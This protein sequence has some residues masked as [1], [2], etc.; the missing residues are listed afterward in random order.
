MQFMNDLL[1]DVEFFFRN[2]SSLALADR[3]KLF[4]KSCLSKEQYHNLRFQDI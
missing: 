3:A 1:D 2:A 4:D